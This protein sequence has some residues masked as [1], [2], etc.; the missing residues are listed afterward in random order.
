MIRHRE[1]KNESLVK[2]LAHGLRLDVP[3]LPEVIFKRVPNLNELAKR[4]FDICQNGDASIYEDNRWKDWPSDAV[5]DQVLKWLQDLMK[6]FIK[7]MKGLGSDPVACRQIYQEPNLYHQRSG[8]RQKMDVGLIACLGE[9]IEE[10]V[11]HTSTKSSP[12][13]TDILV[14]G[15]LKRHSKDGGYLST[16]LDLATYAREVFRVQDRRFVLG[17]TICGFMMRLWQFDRSGCSGSLSFDIH[18]DGLQFTRVV[19]GYLM[20]NETQLGFDPTIQQANDR[21]YVEITRNGQMERLII[22]KRVSRQA[23][24]AGPGT[25]C[26][27]AYQRF[28]ATRRTS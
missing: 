11:S 10:D 5:E 23:I 14:T 27:K 25:S 2:E 18:K 19:L 15:K 28:V 6:F 8:S 16:L 24:I 1:Q 12:N 7:T 4:I 17:F 20:M 22:E 26:W 21:H 13:R 9:N 3:D